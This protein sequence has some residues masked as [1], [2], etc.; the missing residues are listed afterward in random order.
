M[1]AKASD[2]RRGLT[3]GNKIL[4]GVVA[5]IAVGIFLGE[6]AAALRIPGRIYVSLLQ[7]TVL[8]YITVSLVTK[9]GR[10]SFVQARRLA[11]RAGL[12]LL[13]LWVL[14]LA[15]VVIMPLSLPQWD[16][17]TFFSKSLVDRPAQLDFVEL[18][19]PTNPFH[20]LANNV[21]PAVVLFSL[22]LGVAMISLEKKGSLLAPLDVLGDALAR[23]SNGV[24]ALSPWG[25]FALTA[26]AAATLSLGELMRL[27]GY[28]VTYTVAVFFLTLVALPSFVAAVSP[29][30]FVEVLSK[31]R[32]ALLTAFATGKLFAVLPMVSSGVRAL[33]VGRNVSQ[34]DAN[35]STDVL[36][37]LAYPF[38]NAGK[39]LIA[40]FVPFAAWYIGQPLKW[41]DYPMLL[42][43]G[44]LSL[45]GSPVAAIA[46]LL[47]LFRLPADLLA[48]FLVAGIWCSRIGDMLG[49]MH[50][51]AFTL[52]CDAWNRGWMRLQWTRLLP[53]VGTVLALGLATLWLNHFLVRESLRSVPPI[54]DRVAQMDRLFHLLDIQE[55]PPSPNP[56]QR[57]AGESTLERVRRAGELRVGY[58]PRNPP[59]SYRNAR[60]DI[61]GLDIDLVQQ[62]AANLEVGLRLVPFQ[63]DSL[64]DSFAA[65]HFDLAVGGIA[66]DIKS[67]GKYSEST[68][69]LDLNA[70]FVVLDY[71]VKEFATM[72]A[73]K[74]ADEL[75]V[76]YI[77]GGR[78]V[79]SNRH[80]LPNL[81]VVEVATPEAFL[82]GKRPD[83]DALLTTAEAGAIYSM[84]V[85]SYSV[86]IPEGVHVKVPVIIAG[87]MGEDLD[88]LIDTWIELKRGDGVIDALYDYWILGRDSEQRGQR[89]SV[90]R[91]VF[92][93]LD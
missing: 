29:Y 33:L 60:G 68:A 53:A 74:N 54:R 89:W 4:I 55:A 14:S 71:R 13:A 85:P 19:V 73:I 12:V 10:L 69:Y 64:L 34:E 45:F 36:V 48:L 1:S 41:T 62:L 66:S 9:V 63:L 37:P 86:V 7:M 47:D 80:K 39:L 87:Q 25:T 11:G 38:P 44:L 57:Q 3:L 88:A 40:L 90:I 70:A 42:S 30:R 26:G 2:S 79:R 49:A 5:G 83:V 56:I 52:V 61:V 31:M 82:T 78:L 67:V 6:Y 16:A 46:F 81:K 72:E 32:I 27:G 24:V 43:A 92:G 75:V 50:L 17:G 21:V 91:N 59:F 23:I 84:L 93:W 22:L 35:S 65:D 28:V 20:S 58:V 51:A 18:Y 77:A 76:G 15:T 8:P